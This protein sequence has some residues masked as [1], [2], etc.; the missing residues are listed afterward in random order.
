MNASSP[1]TVQDR[2]SAMVSRLVSSSGET[3]RQLS[4]R[5]G[6]TK[7]QISRTL[8][9]NRRAELDEVLAILRA[10][11]IPS[12]GIVALAIFD[13]SDLA[14][15]WSR[16]GTAAFLETLID[17]LPRCLDE[18]LGPAVE[19]ISPKWGQHAARVVAQRLAKHLQDIDSCESILAAGLSPPLESGSGNDRRSV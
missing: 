13:R 19:R 12:R 2:L 10:L 17:A 6:L 11:N 8:C 4:R 14:I 9:G 7:D 5:T 16:T 1:T 18:E 3:Q 15:A